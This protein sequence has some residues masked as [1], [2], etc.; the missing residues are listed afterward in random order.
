V[1]DTKN[2]RRITS[3]IP[4]PRR[5]GGEFG[6]TIQLPTGC[7][8]DDT[9]LRLATCR[10]IRGNGDFDVEIFSKVEVP[11][12]LSYALGAGRG[13]KTAAESLK[14]RQFQWNSNFFK[15]QYSNYIDSGG[16]GAAMRIQPHVWCAKKEK[17]ISQIFRDVIR[18]TVTTHGHSRAII[19]STFH[20]ACLRRAILTKS[21]PGPSDWYLILQDLESIPDIIRADEELTFHWLSN[22]EKETKQKIEEAVH[23]S[24][25][26]LREDVQV[27]EAALEG[28]RKSDTLVTPYAQLAR[29]IGCFQSNYVG[30]AP[31]TAL[32]AAYLSY[33]YKDRP[34]DGLVEAV[35]LLDTDTDTI[36][37]MAGAIMGATASIDPPESVLDKEYV[38][39]ESRRLAEI[40]EGHTASSYP[41]PDLLY[42]EPPASQMDALGLHEGKF[43]LQGLGQATQ[44]SDPIEK[45]GKYPIVWQWLKL[46]FGQ[47]VLLRRR[48]VL[49]E[50]TKKALPITPQSTEAEITPTTRSEITSVRQSERRISKQAQLWDHKIFPD[51]IEKQQMTVELAT[52]LAISSGFKEDVVGSLLLRLA[53][54]ENGIDKS[55]AFA[56]IIAKA[57]QAR[58]K[59]Q[60]KPNT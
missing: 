56:A 17:P 37:T 51:T 25:V 7:Y 45:K 14:K 27:A 57:K 32:L 24:I 1:V 20:A 18:N 10:S 4:W 8:S 58:M 46:E 9:Q 19:G 21:I 33:T 43:I 3:L 54:Q 26:E 11:V 59:Q 5:V 31:K 23:K 28:S 38:E 15:T 41:Y 40:S 34:H 6:I 52:D 60:R 39:D 36:S 30:S 50:I 49:R 16:N 48:P 13:T 47:T 42:W 53:T 35:N 22:W 29:Q 55:V 44:I 2:G 12:W